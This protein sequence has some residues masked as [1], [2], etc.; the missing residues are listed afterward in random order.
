MIK[1][2]DQ[3]YYW[4]DFLTQNEYEMVWKEFDKFKWELQG[5]AA[6]NDEGFN[7]ERMFWY[8]DLAGAGF[9]H[10]I[11]KIKTELFLNNKIITQRLYGNGQAHGQSAWIHKDV[12]DTIKTGNWGSIV[13]YLHKNWKPHYGGN[14]NIIDETETKVTNTFFPKT[15]SA[16]LFNSRIKHCALEPSVYCRD[17]RISIAFKFKIK[18]NSDPEEILLEPQEKPL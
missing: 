14:L 8:K 3:I 9:I 10:Q 17:Q 13:Y 7:T 4:D 18:E 16:I 1:K 12:Q 5:H 11:F 2:L 15:N 6:T